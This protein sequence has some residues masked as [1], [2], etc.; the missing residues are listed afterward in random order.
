M[1][2]TSPPAQR[3]DQTPGVDVRPRGEAQSRTVSRLQRSAVRDSE[4]VRIDGQARRLVGDDSALVDHAARVCEQLAA[5]ADRMRH[6]LRQDR[7]FGHDAVGR[8]VAHHD[9][10]GAGE[11]GGSAEAHVGQVAARA[12]DPRAGIGHSRSG[13]DQSPA[14]RLQELIA[15]VDGETANRGVDIESHLGRGRVAVIDENVEAEIARIVRHGAAAPLS[16]GAP[17]ADSS[18]PDGVGGGRFFRTRSQERRQD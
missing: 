3:L 14:V 18:E 8:M 4:G 13:D 7:A 17:D 11:H 12:Q 9:R 16:G 15:G 1:P 5:A 10:A 6:R 2:A